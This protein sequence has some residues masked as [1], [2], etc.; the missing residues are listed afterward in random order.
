M[1]GITPADIVKEVSQATGVSTTVTAEQIKSAS[2][3]GKTS[4]DLQNGNVVEGGTTV[5]TAPDD[6]SNDLSEL[7]SSKYDLL[8]DAGSI[9]FNQASDV[10]NK[11]VYVD[12][13]YSD[14]ATND[15]L[16]R[17]ISAAET[18][19]EDYTG[20]YFGPPKDVSEYFDGDMSENDYY[21]STNQPFGREYNE[22]AELNLNTRQLIRVNNVIF[23][24]PF[25]NL[26][27]VS[28]FDDSQSQFTDV[29]DDATDVDG[30]VDIDLD[31]NDYVLIGA[32]S[33]FLSVITDLQQQGSTS[34]SAEVEYWDGSAWQTVPNLQESQTGVKTLETSGKL[35]WDYPSDWQ[36]RSLAGSNAFYIRIRATGS[37]FT[38]KARLREVYVDNDDF[39]YE[40]LSGSEY[41]VT[42]DGRVIF[43]R[44][45]LPLGKRNI[46][47]DYR[48]GY[49]GDPPDQAREM[50]AMTAGLM[51]FAKVVGASFDDP[52]NISVGDQSVQIGEV[53]VNVR[54]IVSQFRDRFQE[55]AN[56]VGRDI[57]IM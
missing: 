54:E 19:V 45:A 17:F 5:R 37:D 42:D 43:Q 53:Y 16:K 40:R 51:M 14:I 28:I 39:I 9:E 46:R 35:S 56:T 34:G 27:E 11:A 21:P 8:L 55:L 57:P 52:T 18:E 47:V 23:L 15:E 4:F 26:T 33:R 32:G 38:S 30:V 48:H 13:T 1:S 2:T 50:I 6:D 24:N 25:D 44:N 36:S 10:D 22:S 49:T 12:Y 29:T 3:T 41:R 20:Q 7:S 31:I